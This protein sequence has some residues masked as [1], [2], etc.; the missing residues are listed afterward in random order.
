MKTNSQNSRKNNYILLVVTLLIISAINFSCSKPENGTN[1]TNGTNGVAGTNGS[2]GSNPIIG[3][4][5]WKTINW[6]PADVLPYRSGD[7]VAPDITQGIFESGVVLVYLK[8]GTSIYQLN[9]SSTDGYFNAV[10]SIGK[11]Q[12]ITN[13]NAFVAANYQVRYIIIPSN[14][15]RGISTPKPDYKTMTYSQVC[16]SLNIPE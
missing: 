4:S 10:S 3:T 1:G 12:F 13:R 2:N 9:Y 14:S 11:I 8:L 5:G 7:I 15:A 16:K 6:N